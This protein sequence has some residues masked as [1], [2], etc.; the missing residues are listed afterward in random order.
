MP[1]VTS[2]TGISSTLGSYSGITSQEID[3]LIEA[4][5]APLIRMN[6]QKSLILE[7]QNAWKD[8]RLRL[9]TFSKNVETLQKNET[10][11]SKATTSSKPD[12]VTITGTDKAMED[13]FDITVEQLA[14]P[15]KQVSGDIEKLDGKTIYEPL[16][17]SGNFEF[18]SKNIDPE[19]GEP[20]QVIIEIDDT[21]SLKDIQNK[22]NAESK[23]TGVKAT[24]V[25]GHLVLSNVE[26]GDTDLKVGGSDQLLED[27]AMND[28]LSTSTQGQNSL[29]T[30]D[31]MKIERTSNDVSDVIEGVTIHLHG[32][33]EEPAKVALIRDLD[34]PVEAVNSFVEQYNSLIDFINEKS[35]VG[36]P[37]KKDNK[38][39]PLAGDSTARRLQ[40]D[41]KFLV[42]GVPDENP[43]TT[44]RYPAEVGLSV[45]KDG[46]LKL[47]EQ[48]F[49]DALEEDPQNVQN[50]FYGTEK[51]K[52]PQK[53][54]LGNII[55]N[56]D[57]EIVYDI[58][59]KEYGY[60]VKINDLMNSYLKD[61]AGK[62][63]IYTTTD[64]SF[65]KSIKQLDERIDRF[66]EKLDKKRDYYVR[67][68]SR[69]D[70]AMMQA[71]QQ[72]AFLITQ[73][74]ALN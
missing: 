1:I 20:E 66:S 44:F 23:D 2:E 17:T 24:I 38:A 48:K 37:S 74:D 33:T 21:D 62:K 41:L 34:K 8:V 22:I 27:L 49:K 47:D 59:T 26:T 70:Q 73:L 15:S 52:I 71:D 42:T 51:T 35:E 64:E 29:F 5:S 63:S 72:M 14:T 28:T 18:E 53:D 10:W 57:N 60:T 30:V 9:N 13:S 58:T 46:Y 39:G 7:Q 11:N 36:D 61:E 65:E 50:F 19:T 56:E 68:F 67:T 32:E 31:G 12:K 45:D 25:N 40:T 55:Y 3:Q 16:G 69:L 54:E 4:E 43:H 6:N